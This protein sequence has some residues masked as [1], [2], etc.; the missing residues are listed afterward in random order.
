M[1]PGSSETITIARADLTADVSRALIGSLND[2]LQGLYSEPGAT[3]FRLDPE[4]V[5]AGAAHSY[6]LPRRG[7][8]SLRRSLRLLMPRRP[9]STMYVAPAVRGLVWGG[10][11]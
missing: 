2:E 6:R 4:E 11:S 7:R 10:A 3:H 8:R 9:N 1:R 5:S